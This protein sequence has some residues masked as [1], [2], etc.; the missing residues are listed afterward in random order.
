ME[1]CQEKRGNN[2]LG[3][4]ALRPGTANSGSQVVY[5][6]GRRCA[7]RLQGQVFPGMAWAGQRPGLRRGN[8]H[9]QGLQPYSSQP[10]STWIRDPGT[11]QSWRVS[12][13]RALQAAASRERGQGRPGGGGWASLGRFGSLS[14]W[15]RTDVGATHHPFPFY[16]LRNIYIPSALV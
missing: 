3:T 14:D 5:R 16:R 13:P 2:T 11:V 6:R 4:N 8:Q 9:L 12:K 10:T 15:E 7:S 1:M